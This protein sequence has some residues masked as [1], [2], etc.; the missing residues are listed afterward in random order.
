M[1]INWSVRGGVLPKPFLSP[2]PSAVSETPIVNFRIMLMQK[3]FWGSSS[4]FLGDGRRGS[5][6]RWNPG[7]HCLLRTFA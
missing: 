4:V 6:S 1:V 2:L 3:C 5:N 7:R